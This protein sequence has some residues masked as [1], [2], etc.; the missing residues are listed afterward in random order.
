MFSEK[1]RKS[2]KE[3]RKFIR[4]QFGFV[5]R[6]LTH[7][8]KLLDHI[9]SIKKQETLDGFFPIK[10]SYPSKFPLSRRDQKIY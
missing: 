8:E 2:G 10:N 5:K 7:I 3:I 1:R 6:N 9:E 4:K